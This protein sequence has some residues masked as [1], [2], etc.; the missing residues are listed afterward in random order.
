MR[1]QSLASFFLNSLTIPCFANEEK[2]YG[3]TFLEQAS[4]RM[5]KSGEERQ[6]DTGAFSTSPNK[7][8]ASTH[9]FID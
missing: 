1:A 5:D 4:E 2:A 7:D 6:R 9:S 3:R 8:Y